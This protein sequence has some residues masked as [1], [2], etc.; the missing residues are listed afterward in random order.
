MKNESSYE[1]IFKILLLG[2]SSVGKTCVLLRYSDDTFNEYH[3]STIGLDYRLKMV[4]VSPN[5]IVKLQLWDS[6]GQ[7]RF[8]AITR[9][10]Y[11]GAHGIVL[12]YDVTSTTSFNNIR[13]WIMQINDNTND[14]VK[15][16]LVGNKIDLPDARQVTYEQ[17]VRLASEYNL[18]FFEC[19]A[20]NNIGVSDIFQYLVEVIYDANK[21][22][23][24]EN[25]VSLKEGKNKRIK[26]CK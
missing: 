4:N 10:Y 24:K 1:H 23:L 12:L 22:S 19:S 14:K 18:K 16:C 11:K 17:G 9:N 5:T 8:K 25:R 20:K 2:D 6:A 15:I 7:D 21:D 3:I 13:N 26:C